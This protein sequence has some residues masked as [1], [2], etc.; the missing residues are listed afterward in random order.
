M[1]AQKLSYFARPRLVGD[2]FEGDIRA[3]SVSVSVQGWEGGLSM[4]ASSLGD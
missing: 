3:I 1:G 4:A 2:C